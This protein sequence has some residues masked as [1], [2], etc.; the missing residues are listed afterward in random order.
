MKFVLL[1]SFANYIDAHIV[2][3]RMKEEEIQC[4]L[5]D[6]NTVT[7]DP[8]LTNAVGGI[9]LMVT[10]DQYEKALTLL[11]QFRAEKRSNYACP[12]CNSHDIERV[13]SPR[14]AS[15]WFGVFIGLFTSFALTS[16]QIWHCFQCKAEFDQPLET[17]NQ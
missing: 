4:W 15:S 14:K 13:S 2:L 10:E 12:K 8:I 5:K 9:K 6:E 17:M 11:R 7:L 16:E 3:G 1:D